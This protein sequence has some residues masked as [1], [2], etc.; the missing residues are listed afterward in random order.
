MKLL[1]EHVPDLPV[2]FVAG[3]DDFRDSSVFEGFVEAGREA[4][5]YPNIHLLED[6]SLQL[7]DLWIAGATLWSDFGLYGE[8]ARAMRYCK[9]MMVV[10]F[11]TS[12]SKKPFKPLRPRH[13]LQK[14]HASVAFLNEFLEKHRDESTV[15]VTHH[16][17]SG[18]SL[19]QEPGNALALAASASSLDALIEDRGP[20][21]WIH[22]HVHVRRDYRLGSTRVLCNPRGYYGDPNFET[23][24]LGF[25][26]DI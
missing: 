9:R 1:A 8:Q 2:V 18:R 17:P 22:G 5:K 26:V 23:F 6:Q 21:I 20:E 19:S 24:D 15:V 13:T 3:N 7:G 14:H 4:D 16:A 10:Y 12:W 25:V 11:T